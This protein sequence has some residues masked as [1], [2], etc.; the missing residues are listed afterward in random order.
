MQGPVN[1]NA[2]FPNKVMMHP[3]SKAQAFLRDPGLLRTILW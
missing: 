2:G 1:N 3:D